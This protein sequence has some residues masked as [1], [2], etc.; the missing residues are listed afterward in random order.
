MRLLLHVCC[1]DCGLKMISVL[2][3]TDEVVAYYYNPNIHPRSEY[4]SRLA[5]VKKMLNI[6][7][8]VPDWRPG[9]YFSNIDMKNRCGSCWRLR[10]KEVARYAKENGFEAFS[11][12]LLSSK[13]QNRKMVEKTGD[14]VGKEYGIVFWKPKE[15]NC[16]LK[17][18][19]FY[20]QFFCGCIYSMR[21][22][23]E[24]KYAGKPDV[25]IG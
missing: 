7:I 18:S 2:D 15:M 19:G 10:L 21:E 12:T 16:D 11:S 20:K 3:E 1:A 24:E 6:K 23:F 5:A 25:R 14:V 22:R 4:Q 13:Y 9:D 17:T 8:V